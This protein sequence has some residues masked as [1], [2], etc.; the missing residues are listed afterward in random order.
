[1]EMQLMDASKRS[2]KRWTTKW[3]H[4]SLN[5]SSPTLIRKLSWQNALERMLQNWA[6]IRLHHQSGR[7][8][9]ISSKRSC[10]TLQVSCVYLQLFGALK[11]LE[12]GVNYWSIWKSIHQT[13]FNKSIFLARISQTVNHS[14]PEPGSAQSPEWT[15]TSGASWTVKETIGSQL[16]RQAKMTWGGGISCVEYAKY[17]NYQWLSG[18]ITE[19]SL[20]TLASKS[21]PRQ[22]LK[23]VRFTAAL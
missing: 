18:I 13:K 12:I 7:L 20:R 2:P 6:T 14:R 23:C 21:H 3:T 19:S 10:G 22:C 4:G 8:V 17:E 1:M 11:Q 15:H 9:T 5:G 16:L